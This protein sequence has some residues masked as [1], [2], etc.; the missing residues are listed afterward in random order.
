MRRH[1]TLGLLLLMSAGDLGAQ[2]PASARTAVRVGVGLGSTDYTCNE[3]QIDAVSGVAAFAA[4]GRA[5]GSLLT[6]GLEAAV[7]DAGSGNADPARLLG[8]L[9]TA[10]ARGSSRMPLWGTLGLGRAF[11]SGPGPNSDGPALS[12]RAGVDLPV[13]GRVALSPYAGYVTM[14]A[15]DGPQHVRDPVG[16][17]ESVPT[18]LSSLQLGVAATLRL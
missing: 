15:H 8:V 5:F 13:G 10:G 6:A 12:V 17:P 1:F 4:V 14:L 3:C 7:A 9:A 2:A 16:S 11:W 18:R